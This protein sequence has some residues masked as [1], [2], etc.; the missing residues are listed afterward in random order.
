MDPVRKL[1]FRDLKASFSR[2]ADKLRPN[3]SQDEGIEE[4]GIW[5]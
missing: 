1:D 2:T 4:D 5:I 3:K